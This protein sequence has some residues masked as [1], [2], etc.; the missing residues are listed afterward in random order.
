MNELYNEQRQ[1]IISPRPNRIFSYLIVIMM[2]GS[3]YLFP[4]FKSLDMG[5]VMVMAFIPYFVMNM[6]SFTIKREYTLIYVFVCYSLLVTMLMSVLLNGSMIDPTVRMIRDFFYYFVIF[7]LGSHFFDM[8]SFK[9]AIVYFCV[10]LSAFIILQVLVYT[11]MGYLIPGFMMNVPLNDGG[12][13]GAQLYSNYLRYASIAGYLK[14]NGFLC[15]PAHCAQCF[16]VA[17]LVLLFGNHREKNDVKIA[18]F[19]SIG[20]ALTMSTSAMLY[21]MFAWGIWCFKESKRNFVK[22]LVI[23]FCVF[24]IGMVALKKGQLDNVMVVIQRFTQTLSGDN[25]TNSSQLRMMKGFTTFLVLPL[26]H[27]IFGIGFGN[28]SAAIS[29]ISGSAEINMMDNE[30]MN[31]VSYILVSAGV[32]G[33]IIMVLFFIRLFRKSFGLGKIMII[34]LVLMSSGSSVYSSPIWIWMMLLILYSGSGGDDR[35]WQMY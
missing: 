22:I 14:P 34:A 23:V 27:K 33:F 28:Y 17:V 8:R 11:V 9:K 21:L 4:F 25:V 10:L 32:I 1:Y 12:Y 2:L 30:Y 19:I 24:I 6:R 16:F 15:E 31:T 29:L 35:T 5:E 26:L 20:M 3:V 7:F 18:L 13:T